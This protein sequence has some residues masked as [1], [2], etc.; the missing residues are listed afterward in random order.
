MKKI[1]IFL[2]VIL[3]LPMITKSQG[4]SKE[5]FWTTSVLSLAR[6]AAN[7]QMVQ[8]G[9]YELPYYLHSDG[10]YLGGTG[11]ALAAPPLTWA[12][13]KFN[14]QVNRKWGKELY[15]SSLVL[16]L[17]R[18]GLTDAMIWSSCRDGVM[19][20]KN[21]WYYTTSLLAAGLPTASMIYWSPSSKTEVVASTTAGLL[22][23]S[24][25]WDMV[26]S[27]LR[28]QDPFYRVPNWYAGW[29]PKNYKN[30]ALARLS[31]AGAILLLGEIFEKKS[32]G[33]SVDFQIA[34]SGNQVVL[35]VS[36]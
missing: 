23:G 24:V 21:G 3:A 12:F 19:S 9:P 20:N 18:G 13:S 27:E 22:I 10:S 2:V 7:D 14:S 34:F 1:S 29:A 30:F 5:F 17:G 8:R 11:L 32:T 16:S 26:F 25:A 36:F 6:Y 31:G 33:K 28:Y 15:I 4:L 35:A